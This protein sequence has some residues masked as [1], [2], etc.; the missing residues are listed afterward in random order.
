MET[1][2]QQLNVLVGC[3]ESQRVTRAFRALGH[4]AKSCDIQECSGG[5]PEHHYHM[6]VF[7]A[8]NMQP[9][10]IIILHPPCTK[11]ALS[12]NRWYSP[13]KPKYAERIEAVAWTQRLWD[14][15]T[16]RCNYVAMENPVGVLNTMGNFP[17]PQYIQPWQFGHGECKKTGLWLHGLKP[18]SSTNIVEGREQ[19]IHKFPPSAN[20]GTLR[21][22]TYLGIAEAMAQQWSRDIISTHVSELD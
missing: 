15:A 2:C 18:L 11:L 22:K 21:S 14:V 12:G 4:N 16:S 17:K 10:D 7:E 5:V 1:N 20:R 8:I 6:D 13:S 19:N 3:E 9:W